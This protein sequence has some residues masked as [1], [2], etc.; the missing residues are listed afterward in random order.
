MKSKRQIYCVKGWKSYI[1]FVCHL[2]PSSQFQYTFFLLLYC[3][4]H[5]GFFSIFFESYSICI[6]TILYIALVTYVADY[7]IIF[8][9][10]F[11]SRWQTIDKKKP[12]HFVKRP[13]IFLAHTLFCTVRVSIENRMHKIYILVLERISANTSY[14]LHVGVCGFSSWEK[15]MHSQASSLTPTDKCTHTYKYILV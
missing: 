3:M 10:V 6:C 2:F 13:K 11:V 5:F 4:P 14:W 12:Y 15:P 1:R 9:R 8:F 7:V